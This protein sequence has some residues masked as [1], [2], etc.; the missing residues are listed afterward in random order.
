MRDPVLLS[1]AVETA[2]GRMFGERGGILYGSL[3]KT[4]L[5][6]APAEGGAF[7]V[8]VDAALP[9]SDAQAAV[10]AVDR[11]YGLQVQQQTYRRV[12]EHASNHGLS[13]ES[14]YVDDD[15]SIVLTLCV[16]QVG[17]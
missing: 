13:L 7:E 2:G 3:G 11:S 10:A 5:V 17:E 12:T 1:A 4:A 8:H 9:V 14:E 16:G 6:F 15:D